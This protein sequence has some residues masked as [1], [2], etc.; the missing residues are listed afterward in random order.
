LSVWEILSDNITDDNKTDVKRRNNFQLLFKVA[1]AAIIIIFSS[2]A[3][4]Y[5]DSDYSTK[6]AE[7]QEINLP[8]GSD[9]F[10]QADSKISFNKMQWKSKRVIN[11]DGE[12]YFT[13][14]KGKTFTV[15]TENG[16]IRVLGT[17]F[18]VISRENT[19][20]VGCVSGKVRVN[21]KNKA[22]SK[23]LTKGLF[24]SKN[25]NG[26]LS[27]PSIISTE[28][29]INRQKGIFY[30]E[31]EDLKIVFKEFERQFDIRIKYNEQNRQFSGYFSNK[32]METALKMVCKP[33]Q[34]DFNIK[35]KQVIITKSNQ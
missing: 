10:L 31:K 24:T 18:N 1:A 26:S 22:K 15:K 17:R 8:D 29:I 11:L 5:S 13:V 4:F 12:A 7:I 35:E 32:D 9:V 28:Q 21:I 20:N 3:Y 33:M 6:Y 23:I 27:E 19:F 2:I 34:L 25:E 14:K 16:D 30:F